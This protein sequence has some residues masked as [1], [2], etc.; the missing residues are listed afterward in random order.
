QTRDEPSARDNGA[1]HQAFSLGS[2]C[3]SFWTGANRSP[4]A[5]TRLMTSGASKRRALASFFFSAASTS[6][7]VTG[8]DA[9]G[10]SRARSEY[11]LTVVLCSS[12]WLQSM[13]TLPLRRSL[14]ITDTTSFG[15]CFS[16]NRARAWE[17]PL[18]SSYVTGVFNG[19]Y[20]WR[21]F[22]PD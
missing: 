5:S 20:T 15:C 22:E 14:V 2:F 3:F 12:F 7:Q 18:V 8:V 6:S 10:S 4:S 11:T 13:K 19:T 1:T 17:K 16:S 9:V 21:P